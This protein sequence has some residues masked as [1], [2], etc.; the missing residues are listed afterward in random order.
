M[1]NLAVLVEDL[2]Q[3]H[4]LRAD[5]INQVRMIMDSFIHKY[6]SHIPFTECHLKG[7]FAGV[8]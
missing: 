6:V 1:Q 4:D 3:R 5:R 8:E 7:E 2:D